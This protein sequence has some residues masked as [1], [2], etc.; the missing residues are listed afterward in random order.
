MGNAE[1][2]LFP[3]SLELARAAASQ[4]LAEL[5]KVLPSSGSYCVALSGGRI[6]KEFFTA[7]RGME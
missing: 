4:W 1:T 6:A 2:I 7:L 3:N 5:G